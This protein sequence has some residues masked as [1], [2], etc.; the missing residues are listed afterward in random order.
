MSFIWSEAYSLHIKEIDSQ[1]RRWVELIGGLNQAIV[2]G[3]TEQDLVSIFDKIFDFT[4]LHFA[5]EEK[6]FKEFGYEA[7]DEHCAAHRAFIGR[8]NKLQDEVHENNKFQISLELAAML[9]M[10]VAEHVLK[11][12][13]KY[14]KCFHEHGLN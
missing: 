11:A 14:E 2:A 10:W 12:D 8:L 9:E 5:T 3:R 4:K 13:K 1:H 6:Y 7:A